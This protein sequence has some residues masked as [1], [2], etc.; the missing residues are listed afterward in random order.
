MSDY[1]E[2]VEKQ[3]SARAASGGL[4]SARRG[5]PTLAGR[6]PRAL[7]GLT[8]AIVSA[9]VVIAVVVAA[10][11]TLAG[12]SGTP[13]AGTAGP[14]PTDITLA[15]VD[16]VAAGRLAA[17]RSA[18]AARIQPL[19]PGASVAISGQRIVIRGVPAA[20]RAEVL[21]FTG[22]G[23]LTFFDWEASVIDPAGRTLALGLRGG[24]PAAMNASHGVAS[25]AP[26]APE[27]G[28]VSLAGALQLLHRA[29]T[30]TP[31]IGSAAAAERPSTVYLIGS[32]RSQACALAA[33]AGGFLAPT[34][35]PC[36]LA[37]PRAS[38]QALGASLPDGVHLTDG[39]LVT[40]PA[41]EALLQATAPVNGLLA[42]GDARARFFLV[43]GPVAFTGSVLRDVSDGN[44]QSGAPDVQF[45]FTADGA[46][47]FRAVTAAVAYR[48]QLLSAF[49][50]SLNQHFAVALDGRLLTVPQIDFRTYP[51][52]ITGGNEADISGGY[53][54]A[55]AR[56]LAAVLS[57]GRLGVALAPR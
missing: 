36:L 32:A 46:A 48:G 50:R 29:S 18:L 26:G 6:R 11:G 17:A 13:A 23:R 8:P 43:R 41:G 44:D 9:V 53:T 1:F 30:A 54:R 56:A 24:D 20:L 42:P 14:S 39:R 38:R 31:A 19:V 33:T 35:G 52:G 25:A 4:P 40:V 34:R 55:S 2:R 12:H 49:R 21:A 37:G 27:A 3:L 16:P 10:V 7:S 57:H 22:P 51:D 15:P 47:R 45:T 5:L 28:A